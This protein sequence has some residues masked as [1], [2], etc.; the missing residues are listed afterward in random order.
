[1]LGLLRRDEPKDHRR[2]SL[3]LANG[4]ETTIRELAELI[5]EL[6]DNPTPIALTPARD[7]D[8]S[9]Q[10]YGDPDK[11]RREIGFEATVPLR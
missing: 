11:S 6:T 7:S 1:M 2:V 8:H 3:T 5:N 10:R 9:G 4:V